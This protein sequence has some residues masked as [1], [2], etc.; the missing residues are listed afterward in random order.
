MIDDIIDITIYLLGILWTIFMILMIFGLFGFIYD[1]GKKVDS[2]LYSKSTGDM[3]K[4]F[5]TI[6]KSYKEIANY[7]KFS[8]NI[9]FPNIPII[10]IPFNSDKF[11]N[12]IPSIPT[13][14]MPKLSCGGLSIS[15][16]YIDPGNAAKCAIGNC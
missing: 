3:S 6:G 4:V 14:N 10:N 11:N 8:L 5:N 9:L 12:L 2:F 7:I 16:P 15:V 13:I 1:L